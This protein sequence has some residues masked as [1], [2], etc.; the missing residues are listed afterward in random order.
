MSVIQILMRVISTLISVIQI[1]L[2]AILILMSEYDSHYE[3]D[4]DT[5]SV[6]KEHKTVI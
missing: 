6:M 4:P 1:L 3:C 5:Q 2:T